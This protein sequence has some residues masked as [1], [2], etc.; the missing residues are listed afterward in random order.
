MCAFHVR[1]L[2]WNGKP[3]RPILDHVNGNPRDNRPDNLRLLCPN[4]DSQLSTRGGKNRGR[5]TP[6]ADVGWQVNR[7]DGLVDSAVFAAMADSL[8]EARP[9]SPRSE[10]SD[11]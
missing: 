10:P 1:P 6:I 7:D 8:D 5:V 3:L 4:C 2:E 11:S 9:M